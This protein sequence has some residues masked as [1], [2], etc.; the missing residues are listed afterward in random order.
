MELGEVRKQLGQVGVWSGEPYFDGP[1]KATSLAA[2]AEELGYGALWIPGFDG[3]HVFERCGLALEASSSLTIATG[4]V[5]I[6]R[7]DVA[8]VA[9]ITSNLRTGSGGRFLLGLGVSHQRLIGDDY[10]KVSPLAKMKS[11]LDALDAAGQPRE[12]RFLAALGP[13]MLELCAARTAGTH[14]YF[15]PPEHTAAAR[16][17]LGEGPLLMPELTVILESDPSEARAI[18][19][20]FAKLYLGMPNYANNLRR[21]GYTDDDLSGVGSD[22]LIDS[23]FAWGDP[24][25]IAARVREHLDAGADHVAIQSFGPKSTADVWR[26]LAPTLLGNL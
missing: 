5:N 8:E 15:V 25:A 11:Y 19:R 26:E 18:A 6:W 23:I 7:H 20:R 10:S 1:D 24:K 3:G 14:P 22:R 17:V 12:D 13:K 4:I 21:L 16:E 2:A 9:Q